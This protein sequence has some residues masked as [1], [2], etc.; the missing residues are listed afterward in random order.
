MDEI[1]L[2]VFLIVV[3]LCLVACAESDKRKDKNDPN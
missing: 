1:R 3:V 2:W